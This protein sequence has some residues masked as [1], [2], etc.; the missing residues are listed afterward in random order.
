[1]FPGMEC[2]DHLDLDRAVVGQGSLLSP[3]E[4]KRRKAR[5]RAGTAIGKSALSARE[6]SAGHGLKLVGGHV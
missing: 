1:M 4:H 6:G 5:Q 3:A 2:L